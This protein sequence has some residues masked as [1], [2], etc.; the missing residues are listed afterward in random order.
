MRTVS[1]NV[2]ILAKDNGMST[3]KAS[4]LGKRETGF[5]NEKRMI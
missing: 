4:F 5:T 2:P 1:S 3:L